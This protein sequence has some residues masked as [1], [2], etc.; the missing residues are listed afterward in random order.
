ML[1]RVDVFRSPI[2]RASRTMLI[3]I[4]IAMQGQQEQ[5]GRGVLGLGPLRR[6]ARRWRWPRLPSGRHSPDEKA[7]A[8]KKTIANWVITFSSYP[9]VRH[10]LP[11]RALDLSEVAGEVIGPADP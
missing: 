1:V 8:S 2:S 6:Q 10:D 5:R 3:N 9:G 7:R 11:L 4:V